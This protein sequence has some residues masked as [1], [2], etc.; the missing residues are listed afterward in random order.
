MQII[1][2]EEH[3]IEL[4]KG[5]KEKLL[6]EKFKSIP[7][8]HLVIIQIGDIS[9][10]LEKEI[11]ESIGVKVSVYHYTENTPIEN[12]KKVVSRLSLY[13]TVTA[14]HIRAAMP[15]Y[16]IVEL[17]DSMC[18]DKDIAGCT[19][20]QIG[21]FYYDHG[22]ECLNPVIGKAIVRYVK[23]LS[24]MDK[25]KNITIIGNDTI[26]TDIINLLPERNIFVCKDISN[27]HLLNALCD[28]SDIIIN[29]KDEKLSYNNIENKILIDVACIND[30]YEGSNQE[31]ASSDDINGIYVSP[32]AFSYMM[33]AELINNIYLAYNNQFDFI[34]QH[35]QSLQISEAE[36]N[37][38]N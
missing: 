28:F 33:L 20:I 23:I 31:I 22:K 13:P 16:D 7:K 24:E 25:S 4:F 18:P 36:L 34:W 19:T 27:I 1:N 2:N 35:C 8:P 30:D 10:N 38:I 12:L 14:V 26:T 11:C 21:K 6:N 3:A 32:L 15:N 9:I 37:D 17:N 29:L 5:V